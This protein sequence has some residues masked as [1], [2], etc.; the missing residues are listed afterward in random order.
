MNSFYEHRKDNIIHW[1]YRC[2]DRILRRVQLVAAT[3]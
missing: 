3:H 1:H 2:F